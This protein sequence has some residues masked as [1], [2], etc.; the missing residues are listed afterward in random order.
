MTILMDRELKRSNNRNIHK[1]ISLNTTF[2]NVKYLYEYTLGRRKY[3]VHY[4]IMNPINMTAIDIPLLYFMNA[5]Q[6]DDASINYII[7]HYAIHVYQLAYFA[8]AE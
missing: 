3:Y 7:V 6:N 5:F 8:N 2:I 4:I 1:C